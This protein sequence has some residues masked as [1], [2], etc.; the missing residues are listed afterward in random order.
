MGATQPT[1][2]AA[3]QALQDHIKTQGTGDVEKIARL[4]RASLQADA[5]PTSRAAQKT[6][7]AVMAAAIAETDEATARAPPSGGGG[8]DGGDGDGGGGGGGTA[9]PRLGTV[10]EA[11]FTQPGSLGLSFVCVEAQAPPRIRELKPATQAMGMRQLQAGMMLVDVGGL[12]VRR[13]SYKDCIA[14]LKSQGRPLALR[15]EV[16]GELPAQC[17]SPRARG[18]PSSAQ[19]G[20]QDGAISVTFTE[21]GPLGL[22]FTPNKATRTIELLAINPGTQAEH[23][24]ELRSGM[25]LQ[26]VGGEGVR[27]KS[28][29]RVLD[30]IKGGGRPLSMTF[31]TAGTGSMRA[32]NTSPP[33]VPR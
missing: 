6:E 14:L 22:K 11:V 1:G 27:G 10:V 15:F 2:R 23:H 29:Q 28:Y 4:R 25:I 18:S 31:S 5:S 32:A 24:G 3:A 7:A 16:V 19:E 26:S 13:Q 8:G 9:S 21:P 30:M 33:A 12:S 17:L 20:V